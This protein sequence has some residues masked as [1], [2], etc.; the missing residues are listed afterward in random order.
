MYVAMHI[1]V[2][3]YSYAYRYAIHHQRAM[4]NGGTK[5]ITSQ[6]TVPGMLGALALCNRS[7]RGLLRPWGRHAAGLD[8]VDYLE[9]F[10]S[11]KPSVQRPEPCTLKQK[12]MNIPKP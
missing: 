4:L 2:Y 7:K 12:N 11:P 10:M 1:R 5:Q 8:T 6:V 9:C 3:V